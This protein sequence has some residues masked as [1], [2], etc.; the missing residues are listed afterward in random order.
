MLGDGIVSFGTAV[1]T[2]L[3]RNTKS[4][5]KIGS[6]SRTRDRTAMPAEVNAVS[7]AA[8]CIRTSI[9]SSVRSIP[10]SRWMKSMCHDVRRNS[11]SVAARSPTRSCMATTSRIASS[12]AARSAGDVD[13][14]G[15]VRGAGG[16]QG[17]RA[18][19]AS[20][21]VG[22]ERRF[23]AGR[24][25]GRLASPRRD[26]PARWWPRP[27]TGAGWTAW[28]TTCTT[29][30]P[31]WSRRSTAWNGRHIGRELSDD[32]RAR[33]DALGVELD[34]TWD[35]LR[36]REARRRAGQDPDDGAGAPATWWRGTSR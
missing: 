19:Q 17:G 11:P 4:S 7:P 28:T 34:R 3:C 23:G 24:H 2:A 31:S 6:S 18:E 10:P 21:V 12:S 27:G 1:V 5:A 36:R 30:S 35:L 20:D 29:A 33:L 8:P 14:T 16:Q 9:R 15:R 32:E 26:Q 13:L 25:A 22:T